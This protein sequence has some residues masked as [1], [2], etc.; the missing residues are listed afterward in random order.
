MGLAKMRTQTTRFKQ[1]AL[2]L[3]EDERQ[4]LQTAMEAQ[5]DEV[6]RKAK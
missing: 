6:E 4:L 5:V 3:Q 2:H 1:R